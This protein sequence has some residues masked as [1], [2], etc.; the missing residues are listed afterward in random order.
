[1]EPKETYIQLLSDMKKEPWSVPD[2]FNSLSF[3]SSFTGW[4]Y[5]FWS[6]YGVTEEEYEAL[7]MNILFLVSFCRRKA[8]S[9]PLTQKKFMVIRDILMDTYYDIVRESITK[10]Y[11]V[12]EN[13]IFL[14]PRM[15]DEDI[16]AI[17]GPTL[18]KERFLI[19]ASRVRST[20]KAAH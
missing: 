12:N 13:A 8:N 10:G 16:I 17:A 7:A 19:S 1:M 6:Q 9:Q 11:N 5:E 4:F 3:A 18:L 15:T 2:T 14:V 20:M